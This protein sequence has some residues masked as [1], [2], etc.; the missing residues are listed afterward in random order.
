MNKNIKKVS[1][2][3]FLTIIV[4]FLIISLASVGA[5]ALSVTA[6]GG[7]LT[8]KSE[9]RLH[10]YREAKNL[11]EIRLSQVDGCIAE[12]AYSGLF[13]MNFEELVSGLDFAEYSREG[14]HFIVSCS[15]PIDSHTAV[16][17][18]ITVDADPSD[19]RG[20]Y[21]ILQ[22]RIIYSSDAAEDGEHINVWQG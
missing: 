6:G 17:W 11:S 21:V 5:A 12:A 15:T 13:D 18:E 16:F 10:L 4:I 7:R 19:S 9:E 14:D 1:V 2:P 20:G 22:N 8:E 3:G